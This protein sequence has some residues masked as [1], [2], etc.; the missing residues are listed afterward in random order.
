MEIRKV[1]KLFFL[2]KLADLNKYFFSLLLG[3]LI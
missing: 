2:I 1:H 3:F